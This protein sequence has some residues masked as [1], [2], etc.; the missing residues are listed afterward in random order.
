MTSIRKFLF[1]I[2]VISLL[3]LSLFIDIEQYILGFYNYMPIIWVPAVIFDIYETK[4]YLKNK[5]ETEIRIRNKNNSYFDILPYIAGSVMII[6]S[7]IGFFQFESEKGII[8][9]YVIA[10]L[11]L[12]LQGIVSLPNAVIKYESEFLKFENGNQKENIEMVLI[13]DVEVLEDQI[14]IKTKNDKTFVF[15][16]LELNQSEIEKVNDFFNKYIFR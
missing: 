1:T 11:I 7:A 10:G 6:F 5:P 9:L 13:K 15:Q 2:F 4:K 12:I 14:N 16:H 8:I 3:V